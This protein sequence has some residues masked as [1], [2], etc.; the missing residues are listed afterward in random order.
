MPCSL[1]PARSLALAAVAAA[2]LG[3]CNEGP[4]IEARPQTIT[5]A[6]APTPAV[7][8]AT[9]TVS[10]T[11]SSGLPVVYSSR[12]APLC[13]VDATTGLVT[14]AG[15][16]TCTIAASQPGNAQYAAAVHVTQDVTF[17][18]RGVITFGPAPSMANF[19]LASVSAVE[20]SGL[21]VTYGS[22][23]TEVCSVETATGLVT[24]IT[25]GDCTILARAGD[26]Q[27][28]Q[29][30]PIAPA[31]GPTP[32]GAPSGVTATAGGV[33]GTV[34][35]RV[36]SVQAGGTAITGYLVSSDPAGAS[37]AGPALP[38]VATCPGSCTGYRF[39]VVA[40]NAVGSGP[41]SGLADVVTRYD[42]VATFREPDTQPNDAIFLGSFSYDSS[43]GRV[44]GLAG[45]LSESMTGGPAPFPD[46]TMNWL[47]L[48]HQLS[49][50]PIVLDGAEGWLVTAFRLGVTDTFTLDPRFGGTDG[51]APGSG[52]GLYFGY[53]GTNPGNAYVRIFVNAAD[54]TSTPTPVQLDKLAYA[55]CAP[56]G[57][58]GATCMTG[59]SEAGYGT[60]GTMG[61]FPASQVTTPHEPDRPGAMTERPL[62]GAA[63]RR[64]ED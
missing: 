18:F 63:P 29:T 43:A 16:G 10:A 50:L 49:A 17:V 41:P 20:S 52:S 31:S 9:A 30:F 1:R 25:P 24:A 36:G 4:R 28:S 51:W 13:T 45:E 21:L 40:T 15:S 23:T 14:A 54:P 12:S 58:M 42:V 55:D 37:G 57:M 38:V 46:D 32:P 48:R 8:Q 56:G 3:G 35:V 27:A 7:N 33:P 59:T 5:F 2:V 26:A 44:S 60:V 6:P 34:A 62:F 19:D 64:V 47:P 61:G 53:P 22:E 11:A 39:S